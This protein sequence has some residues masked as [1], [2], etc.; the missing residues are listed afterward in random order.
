MKPTRLFLD[1]AF[2]QALLNRNDQYHVIAKSRLTELRTATEVWTTEAILIEIG[3]A[4]SATHREAAVRFINQCYATPNTH[5]VSVDTA[6]LKR[7]LGLYDER[8]DKGWGLTDCISFVVMAD[9]N[10]VDAM[11]ADRHFIQAGFRALMR[12]PMSNS[13]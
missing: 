13:E 2:V 6:L 1:T 8:A 3:N 4:L 7:A 12:E 5:V 11:T 9:Q 10:L